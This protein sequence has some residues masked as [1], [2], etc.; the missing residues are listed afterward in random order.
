LKSYGKAAFVCPRQYCRKGKIFTEFIPAKENFP[1]NGL[2]P[3]IIYRQ[4]ISLDDLEGSCLFEDI[5][6]AHRWGNCWRN[7]V[8]DYDHYHSRAH[9]VLGIL[10]GNVT[11]QLGGPRGSK[12]NW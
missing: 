1:N 4:A 6:T 8:Y 12:S 3:V 9:E 5:F 7:G 11:V 2:L 10:S